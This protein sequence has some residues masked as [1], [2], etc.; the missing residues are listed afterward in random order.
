VKVVA[1]TPAPAHGETEAR[2]SPEPKS[3]KITEIAA[4]VTP[5][6]KTAGQDTAEAGA[7]GT[8][9]SEN[10]AD[11]FSVPQQNE[12]NDNGNRHAKQPEQN[13]GH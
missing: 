12:K 4:A 2:P 5:P 13:R 7:S 6:A 1:E 11:I 9:T 3:S 10:V 8:F